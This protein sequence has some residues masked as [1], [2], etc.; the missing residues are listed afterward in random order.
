MHLSTGV[1]ICYVYYQLEIFSML[2][3][4][5]VGHYFSVNVILLYGLLATVMIQPET[6]SITCTVVFK[7][8]MVSVQPCYGK[9]ELPPG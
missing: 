4:F 9:G 6:N 3:S 2:V 8:V 7:R 5:A 1:R